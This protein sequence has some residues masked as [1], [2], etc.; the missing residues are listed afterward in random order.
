MD[1]PELDAFLH[2]RR[3]HGALAGVGLSVAGT[4]RL[5][6]RGARLWHAEDEGLAG[7]SL[8]PAHRVQAVLAVF[9]GVC[10][11]MPSFMNCSTTWCIE[12]VLFVKYVYVN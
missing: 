6:T 7:E 8:H 1:P 12:Q 2:A 9:T 10:G 3:C 5:V 11:D 4:Q